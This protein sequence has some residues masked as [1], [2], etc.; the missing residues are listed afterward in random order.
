MHE[1]T[2]MAL[3]AIFD[4]T[5]NALPAVAS[6]AEVLSVDTTNDDLTPEERHAS[7]DYE[8]SR[9]AIKSIAV[10]AQ[11][12]LNRAVEV[13]TQTDAPRAYEVVA[14]MV[15]ATLEAHRELQQL[16]K[17][18]TETRLAR[19]SAKQPAGAVNIQQGIV[20]S[21]TSEELL[22]LISKDRQ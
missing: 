17:T 11:T 7:E 14:D 21:G 13:A 4:I 22:R 12:T 5:S 9:G 3:D 2:E 15:R 16:H 10:E 18:A 1:H 20:F 8:F 19:Q 6:T